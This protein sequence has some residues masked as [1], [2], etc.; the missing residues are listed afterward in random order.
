VLLHILSFALP[1]SSAS[2]REACGAAGQAGAI[3]TSVYELTSNAALARLA[4]LLLARPARILLILVVAFV[5][6]RLV[7]RAIRRLVASMTREK[8]QR[9]LNS[10]RPAVLDSSDELPTLR[11][12]QRAETIGGL[13]QNAS[14]V[15]IWAMAVL[16]AL[17]T[18]GINLGPLVAGAGIVGVALGFGAQHLVRDLITGIF[19][20]LEDQYGIGD[21]I[22]VG[23]ARGT[24]EAVGLRSTRVR[25][26]DGVLW[27]VPNG[28]IRW[29]G[30]MSQG[31]SR[32]LLD[33]EVAWSSD[34]SHAT[35]VIEQVAGELWKDEQWS[36]LLLEQ[37]E[38]WGV[39][40]LGANGVKVRLVA[41]TRPLEQWKVARE[42]RARIKAAFEREGVAIPLGVETV[43]PERP[44]DPDQDPDQDQDHP[45]TGT[46]RD[47]A[48]GRDGGTT[49]AD[50]SD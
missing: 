2:V 42:L 34:L 8:V 49:A 19:M 10:L 18:I 3:C 26:V 22:D 40:E 33:I 39:E 1:P 16:T 21:V 36:A 11:R 12:M 20:L 30:N 5:V 24:V 46:A 47:A 48:G 13:L 14:S 27:H 45:A 9:G 35:R 37:P 43:W 38:V 6:N 32:A 25:D 7:R 28:E 44:A 17:E 31:W 15:V 50:R 41:K 23:P 4:D 29:V